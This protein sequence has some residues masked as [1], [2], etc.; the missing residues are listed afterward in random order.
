[1][2]RKT[3]LRPDKKRYPYIG[4]RP[5]DLGQERRIRRV[6]KLSKMTVGAVLRHCVANGL[7]KI[8]TA[9]HIEA[10]SFPCSDPG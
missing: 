5:S 2:N 4:F 9:Y 8:E 1:V 7:P 10:L 3:H 6:A